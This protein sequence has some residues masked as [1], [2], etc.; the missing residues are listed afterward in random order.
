MEGLACKPIMCCCTTPDPTS[1]TSRPSV[2][3]P[4]AT[5]KI[6]GLTVDHPLHPRQLTKTAS[7]SLM[8]CW[9]SLGRS[10]RSYNLRVRIPRIDMHIPPP[11]RQKG[12]TQTFLLNMFRIVYSPAR[13]RKQGSLCCGPS[14]VPL[15][16]KE[17]SKK[18]F[19]YVPGMGFGGGGGALILETLMSGGMALRDAV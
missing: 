16:P 4:P 10:P 18:C 2:E 17:T 3:A 6:R 5:V 8:S 11:R 7:K 12:P 15:G 14:T 13:S 1:P 9:K 19:R